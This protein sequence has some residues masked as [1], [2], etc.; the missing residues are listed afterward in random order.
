MRTL[1]IEP[2]AAEMVRSERRLQRVRLLQTWDRADRAFI[3]LMRAT[4]N[5]T[6]YLAE[7]ARRRAQLEGNGWEE[8]E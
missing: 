1:Y 3:S 2:L 6:P 5:V 4:G 8:L 7:F